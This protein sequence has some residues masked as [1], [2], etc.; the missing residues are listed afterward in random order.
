MVTAESR[1]PVTVP[2]QLRW[3]DTDVYG[4]VNNVTHARYLEEARI[5]AFGLPDHPMTAP[6]DQPPIFAC[7]EP[8]TFTMTVA[9][10]LEYVNELAYHGQTIL[11]DLWLSRIGS[12]SLDIGCRLYHQVSALTYLRAQVTLVVCDLTSRRPRP[13]SV[14]ETR[15]LA[16]YLGEP[17]SFR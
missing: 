7:L 5:R 2:L 9:Q 1:A 3:A 14:A 17:V 13:L 11:A 6:P 8:K 15:A 16:P 4:H 10:R 12:S